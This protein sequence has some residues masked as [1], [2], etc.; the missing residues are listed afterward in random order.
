MRAHNANGTSIYSAVFLQ[1]TTDCHCTLQ[2]FAC[3]PL[4][5]APSHVGIWT[6]CNTW[7]IGPTGVW[8]AN[9]NLI[10]SAVLA[11]LTSVTD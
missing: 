7:F 1:M 8:N 2:W 4:K 5:I 9:G 6:S 11:E 3:L 10:I